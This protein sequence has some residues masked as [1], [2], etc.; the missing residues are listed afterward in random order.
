MRLLFF[1][2]ATSARAR[3]ASAAADHAAGLLAPESNLVDPCGGLKKDHWADESLT[4]VNGKMKKRVEPIAFTTY[5]Q[6]TAFGQD[7]VHNGHGQNY[8]TYLTSVFD[9]GV[10]MM[11]LTNQSTLGEHQFKAVQKLAFA[12]FNSKDGSIPGFN[13]QAS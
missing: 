11:P 3:A 4:K 9:T 1:A 7:A 2:L 10:A 12:F 8:E 6:L 5:F 13:A